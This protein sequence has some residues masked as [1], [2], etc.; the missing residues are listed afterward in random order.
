MIG[1]IF[2]MFSLMFA[3]V[4]CGPGLRISW[5]NGGDSTSGSRFALGVTSLSLRKNDCT[6]VTLSVTGSLAASSIPVQL[7]PSSGLKIYSSLEGCQTYSSAA[8]ITSTTLNSISPSAEIYIRAD[9]TGSYSLRASADGQEVETTS[10]SLTSNFIPFDSTKGLSSSVFSIAFDS[11]D[12]MYVGGE[13]RFYGDY[14]VAGVARF[15]ADGTFDPSFLPEGTGLNG[16]VNFLQVQADDRLVVVGSFTEYNGQNT[17]Y[18]A[19]LNTDGTLDTSFSQTGTGLNADA[20][21]VA[22]QADGKILVGG[23]FTQYNGTTKSRLVRLLSD[24]SLDTGFSQSGTGFDAAVSALAIQSDNKI[25]VGGGFTQYDVSARRRIARLNADGSLDGT[26]TQTGAG[27]NSSVLAIALQGDGKLIVGGDFTTY[28]GASY[29]YVARLNTNGSI[30]ATFN[31][32]TGFNGDVSEITIQTDGKVLVAGVYSTYQGV[33]RPYLVRLN[34]DGSYDSSFSPGGG[35]PNSYCYTV[36]LT[37]GGDVAVGGGF[38][39]VGT[40]VASYLAVLDVAGAVQFEGGAESVSPNSYV[41]TVV[42]LEDGS[43]LM[44]GAFNTIGPYDRPYIAKITSEGAVDTSFVQTGTGLNGGVLDMAV[45]ADQKILLGGFFSS[46]NGAS[47][48]YVIR[49]NSDGSQDTSFGPTGSGLGGWVYALALQTDGKVLVG[50]IFGSYNGTSRPALARLNSDG[51]LDTSF[52]V[53][54]GLNSAPLTI[55]VQPNGKILVGGFFT[56]YNG[57]PVSYIVRL[58]SDGSIDPTFA[59]TGTGLSNYVQ[60]TALQADGKILVAGGFTTYNSTART[61]VARLNTDGSLDT[62]FAL[63]GSG[64]NN[65]ALALLPLSSGKT[66]VSGYFNDYNGAQVSSIVRLNADGSL[67]S[68]FAYPTDAQFAHISSIALGASNKL[69]VGGQFTSIGDV[70][71]NYFARLTYSGTID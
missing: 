57:A 24:G 19:R 25:V 39:R 45:Q 52:V 27:L 22:I 43:A 13:F 63:P 65:P 2:A 60:K 15:L 42:A 69:L 54:T 67:D 11:Q 1:R 44:G 36:A 20:Q 32:G 70:A 37:P 29:P 51:S 3:L 41:S 38:T 5:E 8:E 6:S 49:L 31:P 26:F 46:Y 23:G 59:P 17:P 62:S 61:S 71:A 68:T 40:E 7:T 18:A 16:T 53:G 48:P 64:L 56:N 58:N 66:L 28:A 9:S 12:R 33:S 35:F 47:A 4:A 14:R 55:T 34:S 30:D 21:V 10:V 50:G